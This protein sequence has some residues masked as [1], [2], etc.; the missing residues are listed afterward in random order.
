MQNTDFLKVKT[1]MKS[2]RTGIGRFQ[3]HFCRNGHLHVGGMG[4]HPFVEQGTDALTTMLRVDG[5]SV[6]VNEGPKSL[7][8]PSVIEAPITCSWR[9]TDHESDQFAV[10]ER[11]LR[12]FGKGEQRQYFVLGDLTGPRQSVF[13]DGPYGRNIVVRQRSYVHAIRFARRLM[14]RT[15]PTTRLSWQEE[16]AQRPSKMAMASSTDAPLQMMAWEAAAIRTASSVSFW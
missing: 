8:K 16:R 12:K 2:H 3:V 15:V 1:V 11:S 9:E 4:N 13:I 7:V 10:I 5:D 6:N 14:G